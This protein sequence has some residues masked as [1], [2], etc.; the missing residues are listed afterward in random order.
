M[1]PTSLGWWLYAL[2]VLAVASSAV[3]GG[4]MF[5]GAFRHAS[6]LDRYVLTHGQVTISKLEREKR[7]TT[8]RFVVRYE[9]DGKSYTVESAYGTPERLADRA[10]VER[11]PVGSKLPVYYD[12]THPSRALL[13]RDVRYVGSLITFV[14]GGAATIALLIRPRRRHARSP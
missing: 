5:W 9:V 7:L 1:K 6:A 10:V 8:L 14:L 3:I 2:L 11:F 4:T 12:P 13:T